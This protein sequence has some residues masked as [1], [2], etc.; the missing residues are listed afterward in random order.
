MSILWRLVR[1]LLWTRPFADR[2]LCHFLRRRLSLPSLSLADL[3]E[4]FDQKVV[5]IRQVPRGDWSTPL[6]DVVMLLKLVVC[7]RPRRL[8]EIGSFRGYT[9]LFLAQH[10]VE[11]ARIVT[12][13]RNPEHGEAYRGTSFAKKVERRVGESRRCNRRRCAGKL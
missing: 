8:M 13:D 4:D 6:T 2:T 3:F 5:T 11:E 12:V 9:A 1:H 10:T 7:V